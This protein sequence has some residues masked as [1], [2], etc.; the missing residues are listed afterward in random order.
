[1]NA[2]K[3]TA[4]SGRLLAQGLFF[5]LFGAVL[6]VFPERILEAIG[7]ILAIALFLIGAVAVGSY[8][9]RT[10]GNGIRWYWV[11]GGLLA[12]A[13]GVCLLVFKDFLPLLLALTAGVCLLVHS[14]QILGWA[15]TA[16]SFGLAEWAWLVLTGLLI[17]IFAVI[18]LSWP[19]EIVTSG[20]ILIGVASLLV[21]I[22]CFFRYW[23]RS[24]TRNDEKMAC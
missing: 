2:L 24:R 6:I 14:V 18:F 15:I 22:Y 4:G 8:L 11:A 3:K 7:L 16:K 10:D 21:G 23:N 17:L 20:I 13:V 1:M 19:G 5:C 9:L 12:I